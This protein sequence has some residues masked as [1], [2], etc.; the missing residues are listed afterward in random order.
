MKKG[1]LQFAL[2]GK[3]ELELEYRAPASNINGPD[4]ESVQSERAPCGS[5]WEA[6]E[7]FAAPL[8]AI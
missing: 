1:I 8:R 7:M 6:A 3:V 2:S 4:K 5:N